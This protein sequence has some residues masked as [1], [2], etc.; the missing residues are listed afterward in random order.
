MDLVQRA[1]NICLTPSTEWPVIA[2]EQTPP[3]SLVTQ[4]AV[5]LAAI[6]AVAGLIGGSIIGRTIPF[7]GT[8]RTPLP[9]G[10]VGAVIAFVVAIIGVLLVAAIINV[11]APTFGGEKNGAQ[12]LKVAVYSYTPAWIAG[13]LHILPLLGILVLLA[14][15]Y[16]MYLLYLGLPYL[17]KC[18]K[19]KAI[20]YTALV[21]IS[22][23]VISV[24][25]AG[26]S[27][28]FVG[29]GMM[30]AGMLGSQIG[31]GFASS[32]LGGSAVG[33]T[34]G[35][36][37]ASQD[38]KYDKNSALGKL[39]ALGDK[40]DESNKK[41]EAAAKRGDEKGEAAAA[42]EGLGALF[43]GGKRVEPISLDQLKPF[44]PG[45]FAGLSKTSS[46]AER[47]GIA[48]LMVANAS[49]TYSDGAQKTVTL[50][51]T[52]TGGV[53]GLVGVAAWANMQGETDNDDRS[54]RT[55]K[56]DGRLVHEVRAKRGGTNEFSIVL[57]DRF[58]VEAKSH[59]VDLDGLKAAV[60]GLDLAKLESMKNVG[61]EK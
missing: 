59:S 21:V 50:E 11:L 30:S 32:A 10:L 51:I 41:M 4:Y 31:S 37:S 15:F 13:V 8:F 56:A 52:D 3:A 46:N 18:P 54:E 24:V 42:M 47:N 48:G 43:G 25:A 44:V 60:A 29:A 61:V 2:S 5:P 49:A 57:G 19:E 1:K 9:I 14:A 6:G 36:S 33:D 23:I 12:A 20:P 26:V 35:R 28:M 58:V 53:S 38:V 22:A 40:L 45:T 39:Q 16:G 34:A 27:A 17:M 55:T 7:V